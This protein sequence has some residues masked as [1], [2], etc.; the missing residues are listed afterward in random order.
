MKIHMDTLPFKKFLYNLKHTQ[1][2]L[3]T[4]TRQHLNRVTDRHLAR[5]KKNTDVGDSPD[6]PTLRNAWDRSGIHFMSDGVYSEV[7]NN[8]EYAAYYEFGHRQ[9]PG[10]LVFIELA[11]GQ[12]KYG[13]A[14]RE[15][16]TGKNKGKWGIV[17]R[18]KKPFV[19]GKFIM[20]DSEAKA[21]REL[22]AATRRLEA[23]IRKGL[24]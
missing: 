9:T 13:Q 6:S 7:F 22:D 24:E 10:R 21:Q 2:L 5:V 16:K 8:T 11:P 20:T 14:A 23:T 12:E 19:K 4:E 1:R 17:I 3:E 18:L 15:M